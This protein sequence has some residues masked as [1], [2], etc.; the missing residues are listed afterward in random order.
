MKSIYF[1]I[2]FIFIG[3][4]TAPAIDAN[5]DTLIPYPRE[6]SAAGQPV[7]VGDFKIL[8][9]P[10][11]EAGIGARE[12]NQR[13]G[14]LGGAALPLSALNETDLPP[15]NLIILATV[16]QLKSFPGGSIDPHEQGYVVFPEKRD[17]GSLRLWLVGH[18]PLG[19]LYAAVTT[20]QLIQKSEEGILLRPATITDW[21]DFKKRQIG[22]PM[23]EPR[24]G[25]VYSITSN[26]G[27]GKLEEAR[28][29]AAL[30]VARKKEHYDWMLRSKMNWGWSHSLLRENSDP[31]NSKIIRAAL[32]EVN[33][34]G[35]ERGIRTMISGT[36][37]VGDFP[38]DKDNPDFK[39]VA[40]HRSHHRFFCWSRLKYH[41]KK[42][43]KIAQ[44]V[45]DC[46]YQGYYLHAADGGGW[47][48][49]GL[50]N[51]RCEQCRET[52][53]DD[54]ARA[55]SVVFGIYY[56]AIRKRVPDCEFVTVVYPYSPE[57]LDIDLV[58]EDAAKEMGP[59][60]ATRA[61]AEK[62]TGELTEFVRRLDSLLPA[63][64][65][66]TVR[67]AERAEFDLM[68]QAWGKRRF[69]SY[70]EYAY[71]KGWKPYFT[72]TPLWTKSL[73]YP[74]Y[75]DII[76]GSMGGY[77]WREL[78][79]LLGAECAWNVNRPG[80]TAFSE[81]AWKE[82]GT[83]MSPPPERAQFALRAS[84]FWFGE[85]IGPLIA[86]VFAE[87]ISHA[88][89][90][91]PELILERTDIADPLATMIG[92][93]EATQRA[94]TSL[95]RALQVQNEKSILE[96]EG[97]G[98]F[99]NM[100][101]MT[102]GAVITAEHRARMMQ[103]QA[104]INDGD[105]ENCARILDEANAALKKAA[106]DWKAL[107]DSVDKKKLM[108]HYTRRRNPHDYLSTL[109]IGEF[110]K[111]VAAFS[112]DFEKR[113]TARTIPAWFLKNVDRRRVKIGKTD[114]A[115]KIDGELDE[116]TWK[117][118][119]PVSNFLR[120]NRIQLESNETGARL[121]Y[122]DENL[123]AA[124]QCQDPADDDRVVLGVART[125]AAEDSRLWSVGRDGN[126]LP[127]SSGSVV[128]TVTADRRWT[129]EMAIPWSELGFRM[130]PGS[131][132]AVQLARQSKSE[133]VSYGFMDGADL[134]SPGGFTIGEFAGSADLFTPVSL[135]LELGELNFRNET[136]GTGS[137]TAISGELSILT[138][139]PLHHV[140]VKVVATDG[141]RKLGEQ[142][143]AE[144][145][146]VPLIWR[147]ED[148]FLMRFTEEVPG[149][150]A[151]FTITADEGEWQFSRR[152]GSPRRPETAPGDLFVTGVGAEGKALNH[153]VYFPSVGPQETPWEEGTIEFWLKPNWKN[154][155]RKEGPRGAMR[156]ALV[157]M[158]PIR[159]DHPTLS[160]LNSLVLFHTSTGHLSASIANSKYQSRGT[161][162]D[163]RSW[164]PGEW[165][166]VVLQWKRVDPD[167]GGGTSIQIY[168][169]GK[170]ASKTI[171]ATPADTAADPLTTTAF[172]P[173]IQIG[174]MN[175]GVR[176]AEA[177]IDE[178]RISS[179]RRYAEAFVPAQRLE[180]DKDT[181]SL[182]HFD[183]DLAAEGTE[184][185]TAIVGAAQ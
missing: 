145:D 141:V 21:P 126:I 130:K 18:D 129:V 74:D 32:K 10:T 30:W 163:V 157:H 161:S 38:D 55:D 6:L 2:L 54:H 90:A 111:E 75:D 181:L 94:A 113:I 16:D 36:T 62:R 28:E 61:V 151:S 139:R 85:E 112:A 1:L 50:W 12:I 40:Y 24:R 125:K 45:A 152:F 91:D 79:E 120:Q 25:L 93:A 64:I 116:A 127:S 143:F 174:S 166:H 92:Q 41:R 172:R 178:L 20:R 131:S 68:R 173:P 171:S 66:V 136:I 96:G 57:H 4:S 82:L 83:R 158:G 42:A 88:Y 84:R 17:D 105:R 97:L 177:A 23:T 149:V 167:H 15:G 29:A 142:T 52:Y 78:T 46:G 22:Q 67:E 155:P 106:V 107:Y 80:S 124:F 9:G 89:I 165:H 87:N 168:L 170:L 53:G 133:T 100:H 118:A 69:H 58:Y 77:G 72:T 114:E 59:G 33:A 101:L 115:M 76:Y 169:D 48:N 160:N 108:I 5:F 73:Y 122:D 109:D 159:P 39:D 184:K 179:T 86:P 183:S 7:A 128:G 148:R 95:D 137:G 49:P 132:C 71:W 98:F 144:Q 121:A 140:S 31:D 14:S 110:E 35:L 27:R 51:D 56:D 104:A 13:I 19:T 103:V 185:V 147:P 65:F 37:S 8:T 150:V 180:K 99:L 156:H 146:R 60:E 43:D 44:I 153:P 3:C 182:F 11:R 34:Y 26:E 164:R 134:A 117:T 70:F 47:R 81:R 135:G 138:D 63:D 176:P 123:Y 175:T 102:H 162:A 119:Q 154:E